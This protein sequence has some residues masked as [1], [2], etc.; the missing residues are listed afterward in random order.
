MYPLVY[1]SASFYP[2]S[3]AYAAAAAIAAAAYAAVR[4]VLLQD[5]AAAADAAAAA[6]VGADCRSGEGGWMVWAKGAQ[7]GDRD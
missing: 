2:L 1:M 7:E 4:E 3:Y 6:A 5:P